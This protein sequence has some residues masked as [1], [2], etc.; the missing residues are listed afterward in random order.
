M[1]FNLFRR[2]KDEVLINP[3]RGKKQKKLP[4]ASEEL[5][6]FPDLPPDDGLYADSFL[7]PDEP[8][9]VTASVPE[10]APPKKKKSAKPPFYRSKLV[11]GSACVIAAGLISFVLVPVMSYV[12]S[13]E[14][15]TVVKAAAPIPK[16]TLI[17]PEMLQTAGVPALNL[18]NG[19]LR[20]AAPALG[21][22]A[23]V[24]IVAGDTLMTD[25][26]TATMPFPDDYLYNIPNGKQAI[27][28]TIP[29]FA[30][31]L[32]GKLRAGDVVSVYAVLNQNETEDDDYHAILPPELSYAR[33]LAVTDKLGLDTKDAAQSD[34]K[35]DTGASEESQPATVT[36]LANVEQAAALAGLNVN[37]QVHMSLI[38]RGNEKI[39]TQYLQMQEDYFLQLQESDELEESTES[40]PTAT[41]APPI[42][43]TDE[44]TASGEVLPIG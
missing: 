22:Y 5:P 9:P 7:P 37:G 16:G 39:A 36:L 21:Q 28:V 44:P 43:P 20:E 38:S 19:A 25:K 12:T 31:G 40:Q 14:M 3:K 11:I 15:T 34:A 30:G 10:D 2:R 8:E 18:G 32:S 24:D 29:S 6:L 4:K 41:V 27:S 23:A 26:L 42:T 13:T 33:V 1:K 17:V 35:A